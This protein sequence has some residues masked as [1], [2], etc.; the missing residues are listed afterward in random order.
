[1][2]L[3]GDVDALPLNEDNILSFRSRIAGAMHA[4]GHDMHVAMLVGA[5]KALCARRETP[6]STVLSCSSQAS[7]A[8]AARDARSK[9]AYSI[10]CQTPLSPCT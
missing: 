9:M 5:A 7:R 8:S 10:L 3:R 6:A 1:M 4:S 2:L